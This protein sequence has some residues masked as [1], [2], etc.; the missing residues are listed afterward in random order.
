MG[1][2]H[3]KHILISPKT[4]LYARH[5]SNEVFRI[6]IQKEILCIIQLLL[7]LAIT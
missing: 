1:Q 3:L 5:L 2:T 4:S 6:Q 7:Q